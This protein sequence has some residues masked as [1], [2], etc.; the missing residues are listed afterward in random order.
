MSYTI[1]NTIILAAF[2]TIILA[3]GFYNLYGR[4]GKIKKQLI[5]EKTHKSLKK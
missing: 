3:V 2:W 4:Q 1:R 5:A